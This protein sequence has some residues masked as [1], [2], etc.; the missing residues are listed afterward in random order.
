MAPT[1]NAFPWGKLLK[2][3]ESKFTRPKKRSFTKRITR[4]AK[5][6]HFLTRI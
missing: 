5:G 6:K 3:T 2:Y 1:L 4:V